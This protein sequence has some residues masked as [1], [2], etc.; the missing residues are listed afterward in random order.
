MVN[1][2]TLFEHP[3][4]KHFEFFEVIRD[5]HLGGLNPGNYSEFVS[6]INQLDSNKNRTPF[7]YKILDKLNLTNLTEAEMGRVVKEVQKRAIQKSKKC[8][9]PLASNTNC[10]I[11]T[12][13][14][15]I[16]SA[17]HSIQNNGVL[18]KVADNGI[19]TEYI[20]NAG[21]F[22]GKNTNKKTASIFWGFCNTHDAIF[23]PIE[24]SPYTKTDEQNFLF[25]YRG[26]VVAMHKKVEASTYTDFG[27]ESD[28]DI[29][30]N[31]KLFDSAILTN[32]FSVIET[33]VIELPAFYPIAVS[34]AFYLDYDFEGNPISHSDDRM[35]YL[36]V[37][38]LPVDNKTYFLISY[39][40]KDRHLYCNLG[41][42]LRSR[43]NLKSDITML[44][45][46]HI[47]NVYFN[48]TYY[49]TFIEKYE[50]VLNEILKQSQMDIATTNNSGEISNLISLTPPKYLNN[51]FGIN[52]FGY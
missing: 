25:A 52:F 33:E 1:Y 6:L 17:A 8:W 51:E 21:E 14:K 46:A 7:D 27:E 15:I 39:F 26:F 19:V 10:Q 4:F 23:R 38:L 34:S 5:F 50:S 40:K 35:E 13:G 41:N 47:E 22:D 32:D 44:I 28:N 49:N 2:I 42:Q 3:Q 43:N 24:N 11:G 18:S 20:F 48:P 29:I 30:E 16:V 12:D 45:A 36:Y 31:K 37:T 9:H